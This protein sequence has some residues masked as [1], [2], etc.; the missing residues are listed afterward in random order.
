MSNDAPAWP[1]AWELPNPKQIALLKSKYDELDTAITELAYDMEENPKK[2]NEHRLRFFGILE[3]AEQLKSIQL[4]NAVFQGVT[5]DLLPIDFE[6]FKQEALDF[7]NNSN[8]CDIVDDDVCGSRHFRLNE[9][10]RFQNQNYNHEVLLIWTDL[11]RI[12]QLQ[13]FD[14]NPEATR[15]LFELT[16]RVQSRLAKANWHG[17]REKERKT[18]SLAL[19]KVFE[20]SVS[21]SRPTSPLTGSALLDSIAQDDLRSFNKTNWELTYVL[22]DQSIN[23]PR[24]QKEIQ[25]FEIGYCWTSKNNK[26]FADQNDRFLQRHRVNF[27]EP[28]DLS[29]KARYICDAIQYDFALKLTIGRSHEQ[30]R[31]VNLIPTDIRQTTEYENYPDGCV[32]ALPPSSIESNY[33]RLEK[34]LTNHCNSL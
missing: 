34:I 9:F 19:K 20:I 31:L 5:L 24:I 23:I 17:Y 21:Y 4:E 7:L 30:S 12:A 18:L 22:D 33:A 15:E 8:I 2:I 25:G 28:E 14:R 16:R 29:E 3:K 10:L 1:N 13:K 6:V 27:I 11:L 26:K 32:E